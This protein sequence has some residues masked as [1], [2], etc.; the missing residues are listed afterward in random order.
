M[1]QLE[2]NDNMETKPKNIDECV[3]FIDDSKLLNISKWLTSGNEKFKMSDVHFG[4]GRWIRNNM[5]LWEQGSELVKWFKKNYFISH[6]DDISHLIMVY[7]YRIKN[8]KNIDLSDDV[9]LFHDFWSKNDKNY[10][11][12][13]RRF[14]INKIKETFKHD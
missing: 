5:G 8:N 3:Q 1:V 9:K 10:N 7:Y 2:K 12:K 14:K 13:L 11:L 6:P 4:F